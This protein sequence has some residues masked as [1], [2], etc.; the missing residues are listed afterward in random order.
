MYP[1]VR[2]SGKSGAK[3]LR[4]GP[5]DSFRSLHGT[6]KRG[7]IARLV[8][9][10]GTWECKS[11]PPVFFFSADEMFVVGEN[12]QTVYRDLKSAADFVPG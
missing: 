9:G 4:E 10:A 2:L 7:K 3:P 1:S 8:S 11:S 5:F 6:A 12:D